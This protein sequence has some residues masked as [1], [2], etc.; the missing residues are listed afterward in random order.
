MNR[1]FQAFAVKKTQPNF[2]RSGG[3]PMC[4][5]RR[6][7]LIQRKIIWTNPSSLICPKPAA[8][9]TGKTDSQYLID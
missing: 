2:L 8:L 9:Q 4:P 5:N 7:R 3:R 6:V 1:G